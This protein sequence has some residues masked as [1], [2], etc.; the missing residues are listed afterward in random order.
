MAKKSALADLGK[1][2]VPHH[3][4]RT[5]LFLITHQTQKCHFQLV[6]FMMVVF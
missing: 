1:L 4:L 3:V 6:A 2:V 5:Y